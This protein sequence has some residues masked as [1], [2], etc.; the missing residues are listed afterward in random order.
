[1][2]WTDFPMIPLG[3]IDLK[4][5]IYQD[6][7]ST[8]VRRRSGR[9]SMRRVYSA[10]IHGCQS[11]MTVAVY[12]G[13]TA[14]EVGLYSHSSSLLWSKTGMARGHFTILTSSVS[15]FQ[16]GLAADETDI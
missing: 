6:T 5:E 11:N 14:E 8:V 15:R 7:G 3:E 16:H 10:R 12:Q 4:N 13:G 1:M 9:R 2:G